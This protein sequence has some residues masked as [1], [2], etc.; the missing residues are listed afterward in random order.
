MSNEEFNEWTKQNSKNFDEHFAWT[1]KTLKIMTQQMKIINEIMELMT[2]LC[3]LETEEK[4]LL[5]SIALRSQ[6]NLLK[7]LEMGR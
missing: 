5:L 1:S 4:W 7:Y 2:E 3:T 6:P